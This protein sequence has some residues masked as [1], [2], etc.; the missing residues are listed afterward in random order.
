VQKVNAYPGFDPAES[1]G[2]RLGAPA[3]RA[4]RLS[5]C[6]VLF[7]GLAAACGSGQSSGQSGQP[8][9][10]P[11]AS[12]Q[13]PS[14][15]L[16]LTAFASDGGGYG[17]SGST[18]E[19]AGYTDRY[20]GTDGLD[21]LKEAYAVITHGL[22]TAVDL[23]QVQTEKPGDVSSDAYVVWE[24]NGRRDTVMPPGNH[25][26]RI[27]ELEVDL[28]PYITG[29]DAVVW[30]WYLS[31]A[32]GD[33]LDKIDLTA[34]PQTY[35]TQAYSFQIDKATAGAVLDLFWIKGAPPTNSPAD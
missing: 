5:L 21:H 33:A 32:E 8:S 23:N 18:L 16:D 25:G 26:E 3:R 14:G 27:Y 1:E 34:T 17:I 22:P 35:P 12:A 19:D 13:G 29:G 15:S 9:G 30:V 28:G 31:R 6:L 20:Q 2:S 7:A 11:G 24:P 10:N 4:I